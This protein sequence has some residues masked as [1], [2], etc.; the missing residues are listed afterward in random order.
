MHSPELEP[1]HA[2]PPRGRVESP[3]RQAVASFDAAHTA[4]PRQ[5]GSSVG[6]IAATAV[7][8]LDAHA[9]VGQVK[10]LMGGWLVS[11]DDCEHAVGLLQ[12]LPPREYAK[13][14]KALSGSGELRTLCES[15]PAGLRRALAESAVQGGMTT[16]DPERPAPGLRDPQ[17][18]PQPALI[19]NLP[20]IPRELRQVIHAENVA[21]ARRYEADFDAYVDAWCAK[22]ATCK[23]PLELR[24]LGPLAA[25]LALIE[26][27]ID[28]DDLAAGRFVSIH[29]QLGQGDQR[30]TR[31]I[32]DQVSVFREELTAGGFGLDFQVKAQA[33]SKAEGP[34]HA[35]GA[36]GG[37]FIAR[38]TLTQDGR[39]IDPHAGNE[40][41][42]EAG[43]GRTR[44]E[45][46]FDFEGQLEAVAAEA[47]GFGVELERKGE[48]TFKVPVAPGFSVE[49]FVD[50]GKATSGA[51]LVA[52]AD[53]EVFGTT[54]K[55]QGKLG[56]TAKAVD[57]SHS[58]DIGGPQT[59]FFGPMPELDERKPWRELPRARREWYERQGFSER[60]WP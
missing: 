49:S 34:A 9:V 12:S 38:G 40:M 4:A 33:T 56:F 58:A 29:R 17:P 3:P 26:R 20:S 1:A 32:S 14:L 22:V 30:A 54:V 50:N 37:A 46:K 23:T 28:A 27:G 53:T 11:D 18:P 35:E 60:T 48:V 25:P 36:A 2:K 21:R 16:M 5:E 31:A 15:A 24:A 6:S 55:L 13:A 7:G 8:Q 52:Q 42:L 51:A 57:R 41:V 10:Q 59:G 45:G 39:L 44:V 43:R 47:G 19:V